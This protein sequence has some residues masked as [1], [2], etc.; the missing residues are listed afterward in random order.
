[1]FNIKYLDNETLQRSQQQ[2]LKLF[3]NQ[4]LESMNPN[5][6]FMTMTTLSPTKWVKSAT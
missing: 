2:L 5:V 6:G 4:V 1:M 3:K